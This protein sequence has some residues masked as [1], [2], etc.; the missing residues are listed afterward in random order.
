MCIYLLFF[1]QGVIYSF[2][3][4]FQYY[5]NST[6]FLKNNNNNN[7]NNNSTNKELDQNKEINNLKEE[8]IK[9]DKIIKQQKSKIIELEN[10]LKSTNINLNK[11]Q[12]L[13]S[14]IKEKEK[15]IKKLKQELKKK[16]INNNKNYDKCVNFVSQ[17]QAVNYSIPC[18]GNSTF[19]QIEELLYIEYPEYRETNNIFLANGKEIIRFK[20]INENNVGKG[21]VMLIKPL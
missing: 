2:Y 5:D 20:T 7:N 17:D 15:E 14:L 8:L 4:L 9:K 10:K 3:L 18:S 13:E 21:T 16:E 12:S 19:A 6:E 11:I 1:F